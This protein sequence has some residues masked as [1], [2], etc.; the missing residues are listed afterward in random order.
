MSTQIAALPD[1]PA[2]TDPV[3]AFD[4]KA[5]TFNA[6]LAAFRTQANALGQEMQINADVAAALILVMALPQFAGTSTSSVTVGTGARTFTTQAGKG[7][8]PGQ[9]VVASSGANYVKGTVTDYTGTDLQLNVTSINGSGTYAAWNIGLSYD[10][11]SLAKSGDNDDIGSLGNRTSTVYTTGGTGT[12]YVIAP[13]P[14]ITAYTVGQS[15][16]VKFHA[17][18][19]SAP[20]MQ[21][22]GIVTPPNLVR[23]LADGTYQ[24]IYPNEFPANH[25]SPCRLVSA[26]QLLVERLPSAYFGTPVAASSGTAITFSAIPAGVREVTLDLNAVSTAGSAFIRFRL[27][28][29]ST[30][31]T[32]YASTST[33]VGSGTGGNDSTSGFDGSGDNNA[34]WERTGSIV[35]KR[36]GATNTWLISGAYRFAAGFSQSHFGGITLAGA[37]DRVVVTT[38]NGT[39]P[40]DGSGTVAL[41]YR[42]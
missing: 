12:A 19:G 33:Y 5:F 40:F 15:F 41:N 1:A 14:A 8:L 25:Q 11:L 9:I 16:M 35:F 20:T 21:I 29:G 23:E 37:L 2:A 28:S 36:V 26:T 10:G 31:T 30:S 39:D 42:Y 3:E 17:A 4:A 18:P 32:G 27:G 22:N 24:N 13:K 7:W 6:S 38:T 34:S